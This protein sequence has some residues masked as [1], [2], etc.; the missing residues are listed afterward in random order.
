MEARLSELI[1]L[2]RFPG[3]ALDRFPAQLSGGQRQRLSLMRAL[4]L[5][6]DMLLLD[7]PLGAL[8]P[9]IRSELQTDLLDI[10]QGL[11]KTVVMVTHDL[12]EA[13]YFG[14]LIVLMREGNIVQQGTFMDMVDTPADEFV[15][16]FISA[17]RRT[18]DVLWN[19]GQ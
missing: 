19:K 5:D 10:F 4:M 13:A 9:M 8:D 7:E 14:D 3:E 11:K 15:A 6:P 16:R 2:A 1:N 18:L 12:A 17:Q